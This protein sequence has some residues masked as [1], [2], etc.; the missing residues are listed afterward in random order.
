[1]MYD[2]LR[3]LRADR[4]YDKLEAAMTDAV[5]LIAATVGGGE[6]EPAVVTEVSDEEAAF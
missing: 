1:M 4:A 3:E 2:Q 5:Q 6:V